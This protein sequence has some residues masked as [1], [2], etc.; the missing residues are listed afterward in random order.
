MTPPAGKLSPSAAPASRPGASVNGLASRSAAVARPSQSPIAWLRRHGR[1]LIGIALAFAVWALINALGLIS[2]QDLPSIGAVAQAF[3]DQWNPL[4]SS[5]GTTVES[6]FIGLAIGSLA[7]AVL[8]IVVGL[9]VWADAAT[10]VIVRM[11]RPMPS[12]AL[13]PIAILVAGLGTTMTSGLVAFAA[14]WPVFINGRYAV[15]Q[16]EPRL[17][18]TG[19]ALGL[20][21]L[22]LIGRVIVP[23]ATPAVA[24]GVRI[25]AGVATVVTVSV[26]LVAG[27]GGLGG[28]VLSAEQGGATPQIYAG[29]ILG[30][31][32]GWL[33]NL[34]FAVAMRRAFPWQHALAGRGA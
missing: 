22:G 8:G 17:L 24:T 11:A 12:L 29:I 31:I 33:I 18:E 5:L 10:D 4:I 23:S 19:R 27:T 15:R 20:G 25:S 1:G 7:G 9:S 6:L 21:R 2:D 30:G 3:G 28:Y 14:F 26:E 16:V 32:L 34:S 13:I